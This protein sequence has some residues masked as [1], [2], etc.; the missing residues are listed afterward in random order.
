MNYNERIVFDTD[1]FDFSKVIIGDYVSEQVVNDFMDMLPPLTLTS[2]LMQVGEPYA[3]RYDA[4]N[5]RY[6]S[7]FTTF[8]RVSETVWEYCGDC[9]A[10][11]SVIRGNN[12]PVVERSV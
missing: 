9:F 6:R 1:D 10:G 4:K 5:S 2:A 11:E 7:T 12:I 3:Q 8:K